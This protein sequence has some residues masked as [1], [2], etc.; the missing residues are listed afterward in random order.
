M[1]DGI[2][3]TELLQYIREENARWRQWL[4]ENPGALEVP[5]GPAGKETATV[6]GML[7]HI[8]F[9]DLY[10]SELLTDRLRRTA[11]YEKIPHTT[12]EDLFTGAACADRQLTEFIA[13]ST[14]ET[15]NE[16]ICLGWPPEKPITGTRRK[17]LAHTL[18]HGLRH[19]AQI[20][21]ALRQHGF[22]TG[23][24]HDFLFTAAMQ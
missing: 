3:F 10:Y 21:T 22:T 6:R 14:P 23:M 15:M 12:L 8:F 7:A 17:M 2:A 5:V 18:L 11:E 16:V 19:W 20:A 9:C 13:H 1:T 4:E 24:E